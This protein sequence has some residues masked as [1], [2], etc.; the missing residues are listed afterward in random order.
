[1]VVLSSQF[2]VI[3]LEG[4]DQIDV[5]QRNE[6]V[7]FALMVDHGARK[8]KAQFANYTSPHPRLP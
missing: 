5:F 2:R 6:C 7:G 3:D 8:T 1:M 4:R